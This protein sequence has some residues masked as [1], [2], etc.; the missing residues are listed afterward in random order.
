MKIINPSVKLED[1]INSEVILKKLERI[2][3]TCYKS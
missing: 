2:D 3:I 1:D